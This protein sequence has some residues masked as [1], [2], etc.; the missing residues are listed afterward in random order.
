MPPPKQ[1]NAKQTYVAEVMRKLAKHNGLN[2]HNQGGN[3]LLLVG[4]LAGF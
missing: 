3:T 4:G 2:A 1:P